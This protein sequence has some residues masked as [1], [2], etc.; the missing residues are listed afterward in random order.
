MSV[1]IF[2]IHCKTG[3]EQR[4]ESIRSQFQKNK[5]SFEFV[6][7]F[8]RD[9]IPLSI[10]EKY[11]SANYPSSLMSVCLKHR[12]ATQKLVESGASHA[13]IFEDDV[14]FL[15]NFENDLKEI[16]NEATAIQ[17]DY[18]VYLSNYGNRYTPRSRLKKGQK[19]YQN[20]H[21]RACDSYLLS[22]G[23]A[24]KRLQWWENQ[25][26]SLPIDHQF[27]VIDSSQGIQIF[28][29][30]DPISEQ[31]SDNGTFVSCIEKKHNRILKKVR[32]NLDKFY[33][34]HILRN[35]R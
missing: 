3:L 11:F 19:L 9:E 22:L 12:I 18:V 1:P 13:L 5:L 30:E 24:K 14:I 6:L 25:K 32:W 35:L 20:N 4:R 33:K 31:G 8:D 29:A 15:K 2:V 7:D 26:Y 17:G 10:A 27:N 28:W 23:A 34:K 21:S 16:L